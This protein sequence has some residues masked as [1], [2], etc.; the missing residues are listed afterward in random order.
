MRAAHFE[1]RKAPPTESRLAF[2]TAQ[3]SRQ[4]RLVECPTADF[5]IAPAVG[6]RQTGQPHSLD[7]DPSQN[8]QHL[9]KLCLL[10]TASHTLQDALGF[11]GQANI[12]LQTGNFIN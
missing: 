8:L 10:A 1:R 5:E 12:A 2:E 3:I 7:I 6:N 11:P 4:Q 9:T